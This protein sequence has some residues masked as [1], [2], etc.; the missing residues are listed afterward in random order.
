MT[1]LLPCKMIWWGYNKSMTQE[2]INRI[3]KVCGIDFDFWDIP[4]AWRKGIEKED[5]E[6][7]GKAKQDAENQKNLLSLDINKH[8]IKEITK[9]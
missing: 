8:I 1:I 6:F 7:A 3:V 4:P 9:L 2:Q 5:W